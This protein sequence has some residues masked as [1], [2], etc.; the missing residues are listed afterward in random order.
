MGRK[1]SATWSRRR[2]NE[3][4][5]ISAHK[6][7]RLQSSS[8][9]SEG[10]RLHARVFHSEACFQ[11]PKR[12][13]LICD[14]VMYVTLACIGI[15]NLSRTEGSRGCWKSGF[16]GAFQASRSTAYAVDYVIGWSVFF[17]DFFRHKTRDTLIS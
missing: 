17:S 9:M 4:L 12:A 10:S 2:S 8:S 3:T 15:S 7:L 6:S 5:S 16:E 11:E 1:V 13:G 14:L